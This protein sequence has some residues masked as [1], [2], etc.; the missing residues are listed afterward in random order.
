MK[1]LVFDIETRNTFE[2]VGSDRPEDLD[3][4]VISIY[5]SRDGSMKT[6]EL[7]ELGNAWPLFKDIDFIVGFN[8]DHFDIP[9]LNK[10]CPDDLSKIKSV[11]ILKSIK[12]S[13]GRRIKLDNIAENTLGKNKIAHGLEAIKWWNEGKIDLIKKYCE[14]DVYIT[15]DIFLYALENKKLFAK[16]REGNKVEITINVKDWRAEEKKNEPQSLF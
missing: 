14:E 1:Y 6:F 13:F 5:D 9:I 10:Y 4:S 2:Q 8:S 7:D 16:D 3:L 12:D 11:D 15:K